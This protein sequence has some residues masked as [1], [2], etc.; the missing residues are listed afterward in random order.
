MIMI[1]PLR[2][3]PHEVP[4]LAYRVAQFGSRP[5][6]DKRLGARCTT[7]AGRDH[8]EP[9]GIVR[10][11]PVQVSKYPMYQNSCKSPKKDLPA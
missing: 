5:F 1:K 11:Y 9:Q 3:V 10:L 4:S 2:N 8:R 6:Q 7:A